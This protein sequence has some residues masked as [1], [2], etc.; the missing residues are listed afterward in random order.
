[1]KSYQNNTPKG[2]AKWNWSDLSS[3]IS[4]IWKL[5]HFSL[6]LSQLS[7]ILSFDVKVFLFILG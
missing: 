6:F 5:T 4:S 2:S 1:M 7:K 3:V